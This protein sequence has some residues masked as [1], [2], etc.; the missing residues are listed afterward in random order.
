MTWP[1]G[2]SWVTSWVRPSPQMDCCWLGRGRGSGPWLQ[3][4]TS[5]AKFSSVCWWAQGSGGQNVII[6]GQAL[7]WGGESDP[8]RLS[9][10]LHTRIR[11][12]LYQVALSCGPIKHHLQLECACYSTT[13]RGWHTNIFRIKKDG[14]YFWPS[15]PHSAHGVELAAQSLRCW[16][17]S[18]WCCIS[19]SLIRETLAGACTNYDHW[20]SHLTVARSRNISY[21]LFCPY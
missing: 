11:F 9:A 19:A 2:A 14:W 5:L 12:R 4:W 15:C 17:V 18:I 8:G 16:V 13:W 1:P 3:I 20:S 21:I 6:L 10:S 7:H